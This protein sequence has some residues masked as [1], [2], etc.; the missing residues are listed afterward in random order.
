MVRIPRCF[1]SA[2][3]VMLSALCVGWPTPLRADTLET[4]DG[5]LVEWK[6]LSDLGESYEV[7]TARGER[8]TLKKDQI[9]KLSGAGQSSPLTGAVFSKLTGRV[10]TTNCLGLID[11]KRD[12]FGEIGITGKLDASGLTL[13][14]KSDAPSKLAIPAKVGEEYDLSLLI[15]RKDGVGDF[16][17]GLV[18]GGVQYL[19][20]LDWDHGIHTGL[21]G[22]KMTNTGTSILKRDKSVPVEI[23]VRKD[24]IIAKVDG[25]ETVNWKGEW[26]EL[27]MPDDHVL[28]EGKIGLFLGSQKI[29]LTVPNLWKVH[30]IELKSRD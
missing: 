30:K 25:K 22:S 17:V 3:A 16:F 9:E 13:D 23:F 27:R 24:S 2:G 18:Q 12:L 7:L 1:L 8:I 20:F 4:K 29:P 21:F 15:E 19:L 28:P 11:P 10:R 6:S 14:L 5:K 26:S